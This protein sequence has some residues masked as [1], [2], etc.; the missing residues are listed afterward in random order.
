LHRL[1][2][3]LSAL[4][5]AWIVWRFTQ[6]FTRNPQ[7]LHLLDAA[8]LVRIGVA[9]VA[10]ALGL[11]LLILAWRR[12]LH[13]L[14][15][16]P[17]PA[18]PLAAGYATSQFG[19]YLPGNVAHYLLRHA[20]LR[21]LGL[22]HALLLT[23]SVLEALGLVL[24][25]AGWTALLLGATAWHAVRDAFALQHAPRLALAAGVAVVVAVL[26]G[27]WALRRDAGGQTRLHALLSQLPPPARLLPVLLLH[28]AFFAV[29]AGCLWLL[30]TALPQPPAW[31]RLAGAATASWL[32]G[33]LVPGAPGGLG[34]REVLLVGLLH[35]AL[36]AGQA[37]LLAAAFRLTTFTGDLLLFAVGALAWRRT[38]PA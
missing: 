37:L 38:T 17:L 10:Y 31:P 16:H 14:A 35:E 33:F 15:G 3:A 25:A 21:R 26:A 12:L 7:L 18:R 6:D 30:A 23:A 2:A 13:V 34:V 9:S 36:P 8:L 32:G 29:M 27:A 5:L 20:D 28:A 19:K 11:G 24:A 22:T 4:A 1:G